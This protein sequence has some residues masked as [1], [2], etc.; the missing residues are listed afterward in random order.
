[1]ITSITV[2]LT[3]S[4][5][6][7][8]FI[9]FEPASGSWTKWGLVGAVFLGIAILVQLFALWRALQPDDEQVKVYRV[10]LRW[11]TAGIIFLVVGMIVEAIA[12]GTGDGDAGPVGLAMCK[13]LLGVL[14]QDD[15]GQPAVDQA[16]QLCLALAERH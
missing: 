14:V 16:R 9:V 12:F 1:L 8:K 2:V 15:P 13:N 11:F 5:L 7:F 4:L 10:T 3:G 6:L